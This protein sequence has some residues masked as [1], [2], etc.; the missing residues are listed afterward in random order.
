MKYMQR[1]S[2]VVLL[3]IFLCVPPAF[4]NTATVSGICYSLEFESASTSIGGD[5]IAIYYTTC[6]GDRYSFPQNT[7]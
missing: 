1:S 4:A 2:L 5:V 6:D 7:D 3:I